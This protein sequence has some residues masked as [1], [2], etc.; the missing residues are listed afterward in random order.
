MAGACRALG[1]PRPPRASQEIS[2][3]AESI[4]AFSAP[5]SC[6]FSIGTQRDER[7][8]LLDTFSGLDPRFITDAERSEGI[9]AKNQAA[10]DGGFYVTE[11]SQVIANFAEW[12]NID[13]IVGSVPETLSRVTSPTVAFLSID[14]NCTPPKSPQWSSSGPS[15]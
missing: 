9:L 1:G 8:F 12:K 11:Q 14:M 10:I 5:R 3:N 6:D 4:A 7:F 13:I 15:S 2:S